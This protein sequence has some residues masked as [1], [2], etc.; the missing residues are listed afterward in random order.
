MQVTTETSEMESYKVPGKVT[1]KY[2][3]RHKGW[4]VPAPFFTRYAKDAR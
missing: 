4:I 1:D 3:A 2:R